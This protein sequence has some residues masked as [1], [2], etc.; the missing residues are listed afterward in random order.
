[1]HPRAT[2]PVL[3]G[4][5]LVTLTAACSY[6]DDAAPARSTTSPATMTTPGW[7]GGV[8]SNGTPDGFNDAL[9]QIRAQA[10]TN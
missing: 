6:T 2:R 4:F 7:Y 3:A 5:T 8:P 10:D 1:M 9:A